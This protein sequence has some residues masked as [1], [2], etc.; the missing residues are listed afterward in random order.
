MKKSALERARALLKRRS[1][2]QALTILE[3]AEANY[4]DSFDYYLT[5]GIAC[6]YLGIWGSAV[7][8]FQQARKIRVTETNLLLSQAVLYLRRGDT[9]RALQY[10]LDVLDSDPENKTA[11][12]A[13][14]FIRTNG[15]YE[16]ICNWFD[17]GRIQKFYPPLGVNPS[18]VM[19]IV[20]SAVAG[21]A[22]GLGLIFVFTPQRYTDSG[23]RADLSTLALT[24]DEMGNLHEKDLSG[25]VYHY[26]LTD[27]E[28]R[29]SYDNARQYFQDYRDNAATVEINRILN[30]NA[31]ASVRQ[32]A[33]LLLTYFE[34]P[35]FD[36]L[37]D[38]YSYGQIAEDPALYL[39]CWV[40]WSGR[41]TN[42]VMEDGS[43]RC[44]LL[45]GYEDLQRVEGIVPLF[46][47]VAPVPEIDGARS[48]RVLAKVGME[49]G[50]LSLLGRSVYQP[51]QK[52]TD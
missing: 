19:R 51:L 49:N 20:C 24:A 1:F 7:S 11:K 22:L 17:S 23:K 36:S 32:K 9:D 48:V 12:E 30:S 21:V 50:K 45:V 26:I 3:A 47:S 34:E 44:D 35:T 4:R 25:A 27:K 33:S 10:Y 46:F 2:G 38:N 13:M 43:F 52:S 40:S 41:I 29:A 5:A 8:Y 15:N 18:K 14:E 37:T 39:G 42:A 28:I 6:L 31:S 16:T